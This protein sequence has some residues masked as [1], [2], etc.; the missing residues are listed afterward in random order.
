LAYL[1]NRTYQTYRSYVEE[2][3][4]EVAANTMICVTHQ[5]NYLIDQQL[6][7]LEQGFLDRGGFTE[8]LYHARQAARRQQRHSGRR[9]PGGHGD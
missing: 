7:G 2:G 9:N 4:P 8:R 1:P 3:S 5:A 6:R